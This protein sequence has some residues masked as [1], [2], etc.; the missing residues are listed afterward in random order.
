MKKTILTLIA[1]A[2]GACGASSYSELSTSLK[3]GMMYAWDFNDGSAI[4]FKAPGAA[5]LT[6]ENN[7]T[8]NTGTTYAELVGQN[9][10]FNNDG[11]TGFSN[12]DFTV[13]IDVMGL[14]P[15]SWNNVLTLGNNSSQLMQ[16]QLSENGDLIF[17]NAMGGGL[18]QSTDTGI[19]GYAETWSTLTIVSDSTNKT[20]SLYVDGSILASASGWD[21]GELKT[22]SVG[23]NSKG[24]N[25]IMTDGYID[26]LYVWNRALSA[27]EVQALIP[28]PTTATLS[29]LALCGLC[30]R[31][32]RK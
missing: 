25:R 14:G 1:L 22:L 7:S 5:N 13:S 21:A 24:S 9:C 17:Y 15:K 19:N 27:T 32:R 12:G 8:V 26:N 29:L 31:R 20:L 4:T 23:F 11:L 30:A 16:V 2:G 28:E 3:A 18:L 6:N 10:I